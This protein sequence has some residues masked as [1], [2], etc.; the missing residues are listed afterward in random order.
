MSTPISTAENTNPFNPSNVESIVG[1]TFIDDLQVKGMDRNL[2]LEGISKSLNKLVKIY[3]LGSLLEHLTL[4]EVHPR[5]RNITSSRRKVTLHFLR[6]KGDLYEIKATVT[7]YVVHILDRDNCLILRNTSDHPILDVST[8]NYS[9]SNVI[10]P[11]V[12]VKEILTTWLEGKRSLKNTFLKLRQCS[13]FDEFQHLFNLY[14]ISA[15]TQYSQI[16]KED[17]LVVTY[18]MYFDTGKGPVF[19]ISENLD[20]HASLPV[21]IRD[22]FRA[23]GGTAPVVKDLM[24]STT[25]P[26]HGLDALG[27]MI[28]SKLI[29]RHKLLILLLRAIDLHYA[30]GGSDKANTPLVTLYYSLAQDIR[31]SINR[32][33]DN[34]LSSDRMRRSILSSL[35]R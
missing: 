23:K 17:R 18:Q 27:T 20:V 33:L 21:I 9:K 30:H 4:A 14:G 7:F 8:G 35:P 16:L 2:L 3:G 12:L 22:S 34:A 32:I 26:F 29:T 31:V 25:I 24:V 19:E 28:E 13:Y 1:Y 5:E 10:V 11:T 15:R 6:P